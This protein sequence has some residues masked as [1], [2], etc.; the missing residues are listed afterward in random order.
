MP[1]CGGQPLAYLRREVPAAGTSARGA[2][3]A[4]GYGHCGLGGLQPAPLAAQASSFLLLVNN[5]GN[6]QDSYTA[7]IIGT[8]GPVSASHP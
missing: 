7:T 3:S 5:I 4:P 8:T 6:L 1:C 2:G